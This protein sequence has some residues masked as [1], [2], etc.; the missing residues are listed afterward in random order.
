MFNKKQKRIK[1]LET[2]VS[3][4]I[5]ELERQRARTEHAYKD[6]DRLEMQNKRL[7]DSIVGY[8]KVAGI[9][10]NPRH[11]IKI[12][13]Y[14]EISKDDNGGITETFKVPELVISMY[15]NDAC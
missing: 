12:P 15:K 2:R 8:L 7:I 5:T 1:D 11:Q 13:Y 4:L 6:V 14:H 3:L 10:I 9:E